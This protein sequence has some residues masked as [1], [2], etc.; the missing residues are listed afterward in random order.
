MVLLVFSL[1]IL[2]KMNVS[3]S[4]LV[5]FTNLKKFYDSFVVEDSTI[6]NFNGVYG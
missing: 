5:T 1:I 6:C 2:Y 3:N 4:R